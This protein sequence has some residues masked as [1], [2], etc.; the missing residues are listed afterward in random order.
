LIIKKLFSR[1]IFSYEFR[2]IAASTLAIAAA[3][4][5]A[6]AQDLGYVQISTAKGVIQGASKDPGHLGWIKVSKVQYVTRIPT[7]STTPAGA[8]FATP[9]NQSA[10][11]SN[12]ARP[13]ADRSGNSDAQATGGSRATSS[14][15]TS[16]AATAVAPQNN[17]EP[18]READT[19]LR[20]SRSNQPVNP[21]RIIFV[22]EVDRLSP[23]L[24]Q[25]LTSGEK[26]D[27]VIVD[28]Y[29]GGSLVR[30]TLKDVQLNSIQPLPSGQEKY[31]GEIVS[32]V[33]IAPVPQK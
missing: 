29:R 21:Q 31:P 14:Q 33:A 17:T 1:F 6:R 20:D 22:K 19:S 4:P 5:L 8:T 30:L 16:G 2:L 18:G 32:L 28:F 12:G 27:Q 10:T 13:N 26:F 9:Q 25:A 3:S 7:V 15:G 24:K 23:R 11:P